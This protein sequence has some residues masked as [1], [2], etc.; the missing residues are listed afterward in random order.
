MFSRLAEVSASMRGSKVGPI[1]TWDRDRQ[2]FIAP[3]FVLLNVKRQVMRTF[4]ACNSRFFAL[5]GWPC[6]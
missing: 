1:S 5:T 6:V 3:W 2:L 4:P